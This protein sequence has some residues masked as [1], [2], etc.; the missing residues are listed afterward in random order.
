VFDGKDLAPITV[1]QDMHVFA[2]GLPFEDF[3]RENI[4]GS[5]PLRLLDARGERP[6]RARIVSWWIE[7]PEPVRERLRD[8]S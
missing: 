3:V 2:E 6:F 5:N 8:L 1:S 7:L 4:L